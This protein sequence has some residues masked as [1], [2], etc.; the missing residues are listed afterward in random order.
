MGLCLTS[1]IALNLHIKAEL[2]DG[3]RIMI[4]LGISMQL[5]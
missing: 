1:D 2:P 4:L 3:N 5:N